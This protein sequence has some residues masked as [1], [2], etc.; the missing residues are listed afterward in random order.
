[1]NLYW[2][3][4]QP[5]PGKGQ[6]WVHYE[7][8]EKFNILR[9]LTHFPATGDVDCVKNPIVK[10]MTDMYLMDKSTEEEFSGLWVD[11]PEVEEPA[12]AEGGAPFKVFNLDMTVAEA[13]SLHPRVSEIFA[14]FR[15]GGCGSCGIGEVE[16][17]RQVCQA[18]GVDG[19]LLQEVVDDL[20]NPKEAQE[21]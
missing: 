12:P 13:M 6:A 10:R 14:A 17:V 18:Y 15:L 1:M 5:V 7:C 2:K 16:T 9:H 4:S 19:E 8:D 21:A 3:T 20:L 11:P